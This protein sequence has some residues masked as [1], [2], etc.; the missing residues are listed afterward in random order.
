MTSSTF[1]VIDLFC[2]FLL[3]GWMTVAPVGNL[4]NHLH[5]DSPLVVCSLGDLQGASV[6]Q[7][8]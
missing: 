8:L 1:C 2:A 6:T 4:L 5:R 7:A 3:A